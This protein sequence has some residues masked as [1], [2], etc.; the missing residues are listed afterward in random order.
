ME[1]DVAAQGAGAGSVELW[2]LVGNL[3]TGQ[4]VAFVLTQVLGLSYLEAA[5]V[6]GCPVGTIRA[7][8]ARARS[9]LAQALAEE[10]RARPG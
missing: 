5:D 3:G 7:R 6:V 10:R 2:S 1:I 8:V 9:S 4:R